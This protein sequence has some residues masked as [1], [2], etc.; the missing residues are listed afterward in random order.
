MHESQKRF[1]PAL[2]IG[3]L[4][5]SSFF[6]GYFIGSDEA[7][8]SAVA[9]NQSDINE[10][11]DFSPFW[12][13]WKVLNEKQIDASKIDTKTKLWSSIEG[14]AASY[15]DPYTV[16]FPPQQS[17]EFN[18]EISGNFDGIG[19]EVGMKDDK[20]T[21]VAPL[22]GTPAE[23]A[24]VLSG[25]I[26]LEVDGTSTFGMTIDEAV[27]KIRGKKGTV[28]KL[29][30]A[31]K[32]EDKPLEISITRD[33]IQVPTLDTTNR[34][35]GVFVISVY[36]FSANVATEF[37]K[38][39]DEFSKSGSSK[40]LID[41]RGNPGGYLDAAVEMAS[42]FLPSG[43]V[44]VREEGRNGR[45]LDVF[46]SKGY[47][48]LSGTKTKVVVL[49]DQGS[50]SA[51]E[52]FAG[53]LQE[54]GVAKLVGTQT[55]GKGSVQEVVQ[56]TPDTTLKVTVAKWLTPNGTSISKEGLTPDVVV[57]YV[58]DEANPEHDNQLDRA[59]EI[60]LGN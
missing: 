4:T 49:V 13:T 47:D 32:G 11:V 60:L 12:K 2:L 50:A 1:L 14:L 26:I 24:G 17:K 56:I 48:I 41:L 23:K 10:N 52:I 5:L 15:G 20:I 55:F 19:M 57:K 30:I 6:I 38:A 22:K 31:R 39:L 43:K 42:Y 58:R 25:D 44:I 18:E 9:V 7:T 29:T 35:D 36:N 46:R 28:V 54:N 8:T 53:A 21:V 27:N 51:S 59:V 40:L 37:I 45:E 16:F 33:S 34:K 3:V